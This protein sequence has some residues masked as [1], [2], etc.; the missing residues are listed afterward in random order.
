MDQNQFLLDLVESKRAE[1]DRVPI[2][3]QSE[4]QRV[5]TAVWFLEMGVNNGG[6][7]G[8]LFNSTGDTAQ[9]VPSAL[10]K[11]GAVTCADIV[12]RALVA[13]SS[14]PLPV[15]ME[16]RRALLTEVEALEPFDAEFYAYPDDLTELLYG[17]VQEHPEEFGLQPKAEEGGAQ[18]SKVGGA[19]E[20][21][22]L[23]HLLRGFL[24]LFGKKD[25][26]EE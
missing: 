4:P 6:F 15:D 25:P 19:S 20:K 13:V 21:A 22:G 10:R 26:G 23:A 7:D 16:G 5:F 17:Y 11:I 1:L 24:G 9:H 14:V 2:E 8:Y 3:E 18:E 12:E